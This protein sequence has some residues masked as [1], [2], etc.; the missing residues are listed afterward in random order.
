AHMDIGACALGNDVA[1]VGEGNADDDLAVGV[2]NTGDQSL[3]QQA[4]LG[5]G[6]VHFPVAGNNSLALLLIHTIVPPVILSLWVYGPAF[7]LPHRK[8]GAAALTGT[9]GRRAACGC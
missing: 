4:R 9:S 3:Q 2:M 6:V 7:C 8:S 1:Q 5:G